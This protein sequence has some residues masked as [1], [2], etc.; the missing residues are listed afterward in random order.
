MNLI[1][2][3]HLILLT[4]F[5]ALVG[6]SAIA[7]QTSASYRIVNQV[8]SAGGGYHTSTSYSLSSVIGQASPIGTS[9]NGNYSLTTGFLARGKTELASFK[10]VATSNPSPICV[11]KSF[12]ITFQTTPESKSVDGVEFSLKFDPTK[13]QANTIA[14]SGI[15]DD[16]LTEDI[17]VG[18][19]D[20][21]AGVWD[22]EAPSGEFKLV[23]FNF[24]VL[25]AT[26]GADL[27]IDSAI[28]TFEGETLLVAA[29]DETIVTQECMECKVALQGRPSIPPAN[30][31]WETDL[32]IYVGDKT[33]YTIE[34]DGLG[35]C[36]LPEPSGNYSICVKGSHTLANRIGPPLMFGGDNRLDFGTLLE[37][38]VDDDNDV[39]LL[40]R[41][42]LKTSKDKCQDADGYIENADL[43]EDDCVKRADY[44]LFKANYK[45]PKGNENPAI[46]EWDTSVT[47]PTL[48]RGLR[49]GGG[50]VTLRVIIPTTLNVGNAFNATIQVHADENQ[51]VD[52][53]AAYLNFDPNL[54]RVNEI[55]ASEH[56]DSVL[57]KEF[58]N[59]KGEINFAAGA[60]DND[61]PQ[62]TFTLATVNFTLLDTSGEETLSFNTTAPRKTESISGGQSVIAP[63]GQEGEIVIEAPVI[64]EPTGN[65]TAYGTIRDELG[66]KLAGVEVQVAGK[67]VITDAA[68]NWE[69]PNLQEGDY[70]IT[71]SK[72]G[73]TFAPENV[74]LGNDEFRQEAVLKPLS[75]LKVKVVAEPRTVK[76]SDNVTYIAT[77]I[78]G[79]NET[80]T[81]VVLNNVLATN[82]GGLVSIEALDGGECDAD[83]VTCTLP[84]LT[85]GNSARV[86]LVVSN[87]QAKSLSNTATVTS[88]E[89]P[90]DVQKTRTQVIP[91]LAASI[92]DT[93][94]PLQLPLPGEERMLHYDVAATLS[95]NAPSAATGVNLVMTLPKGVELQAVN[96]DNGMCD[97]SQ[98]PT[99]TCQLTDLSVDDADSIS[100]VTVGVDVALKD[101]GLLTLTLEA[102]VS[103]NEYSV[104]TDKERTKI[105]IDPKYKVDIA[106]VI[107]DTGSMQSE[108]NQV[109]VAVNKVIDAIDPSEAPMSVLLTFGDQVKYRAVTQDLTVLRD[110]VGKLKATGGGTCPEASYEAISFAIPHVKEGGTILFATDASPY[111]GSD[112]DDMMARLRS[113]GIIFN[114]MVFGDCADENSWNQ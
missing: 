31:R 72:D 27:Q 85:T 33:P 113:N 80:A 77:V 9:A 71:V 48:R 82:A 111:E 75:K 28:A 78:N 6:N 29:D 52:T 41:S 50:S 91:H 18:S 69:V 104:H 32:K 19:I 42:L 83:T 90:A 93:P 22:N 64:E 65:Y 13:L 47:P 114:A 26:D 4:V 7:E 68:G 95:A 107:D 66:N 25:A 96:S 103:A 46:C 92:T 35:H 88:N 61:I 99:L 57:E 45:K 109:K 10:L 74:A 79:G 21:A 8:L 56:F 14:N 84:D 63:S 94:E 86:K 70:T 97:T 100:H 55:T 5:F 76:Q 81:G 102:K 54:L 11:G 60:W 17:N 87:T 16:V 40:D 44:N 101:A 30:S 3:T 58:D 2:T 15:L 38:D 34:T 110:A 49:D 62:G 98:L 108:I 24:T 39:D 89:Y 67:T 53:A 36:I 59:E 106:F 1:K 12:D 112:V 51:A 105:F 43:D 37:G 73:Y 23:T 20:F